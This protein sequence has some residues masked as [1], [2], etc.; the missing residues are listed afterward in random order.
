MHDNSSEG[1]YYL[2]T[3][4]S[5]KVNIHPSYNYMILLIILSKKLNLNMV[6]MSSIFENKEKNIDNNGNNQALIG[7]GGGG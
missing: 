4:N 6:D 1:K 2:N 5:V 7:T 3:F